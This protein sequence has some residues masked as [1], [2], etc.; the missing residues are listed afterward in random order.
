MDQIS[1]PQQD[2][3]KIGAT[4][5]IAVPGQANQ[6]D[7]PATLRAQ[8]DTVSIT[9][10]QRQLRSAKIMIVDDEDLVIRVVRRFLSADGYTQFVTLSDPRLALETIA[11]EQPDVVLLD[12]MM[13]HIT[14]L[15][16]LKVRQKTNFASTHPV[17]YF[18]CQLG[19]PDQTRSTENGR[20]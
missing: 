18:K 9:A 6:Q 5:Q 4:Q 10:Q 1:T 2:S 13:P 11:R 3:L 14:G 7:S 16:L 12:I 15:D 19:K 17:H 20:D 8:E